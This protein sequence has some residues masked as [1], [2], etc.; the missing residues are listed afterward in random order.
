VPTTGDHVNLYI[1]TSTAS[2]AANAI[3]GCIQDPDYLTVPSGSVSITVAQNYSVNNPLMVGHFSATE[4]GAT[5]SASNTGATGGVSTCG[6]ITAD[7]NVTLSASSVTNSHIVTSDNGNVIV[8]GNGPG[9]PLTLANSGSLISDT[10]AVDLNAPGAEGTVSVTGTGT[11][12]APTVNVNIGSGTAS[13]TQGTIS[14]LIQDPLASTTQ[15][16]TVA[17]TV[18][19]AT[20]LSLGAFNSTT[21]VTATNNGDAVSGTGDVTILANTSGANG[22]TVQALGTNGNVTDVGGFTLTSPTS[23]TLLANGGPTSGAGGTSGGVGD[24]ADPILVNTPVLTANAPNGSV[25]VTDSAAVVIT[26]AN[27]ANGTNAGTSFHLEDD[28]AVAN[29]ISFA[30]GSSITAF[31]TILNTPNGGI[32]LTGANIAASGGAGTGN[33]EIVTKD[34]IAGIPTANFAPGTLILASTA[35][36]I[37]SANTPLVTGAA[38]ISASAPTGGVFVDDTNTGT[39]SVI[40]PNTAGLHCGLTITGPNT[41]ATQYFIEGS[42]SLVTGT[43][44]TV[45]APSV[46]ISAHNNIGTTGNGFS[47]AAQTLTA[48][49]GGS[50]NVA[51]N[52]ATTTTLANQTVG[53]TGTFANSAGGSFTITQTGGGDLSVADNN[54]VTGTTGV[55]IT[56]AVLNLGV[57]SDVSSSAGNVTI[58]S[59]TGL[60]LTVNMGDGSTIEAPTGAVNFDTPAFPGSIM[61][62]GTTG[63]ITGDS[64]SFNGGTGGSPVNVNVGKIDAPIS[65]TGSAVSITT[66]TGNVDVVSNIDTSSG[67]GPGG[68]VT[69]VAMGGAV[70]AQNITTNG[71]NTG[72]AGNITINSNAP[73]TFGDLSANGSAGAGAGII[74]ITA[75][76]INGGFIDDTTSGSTLPGGNVAITTTSLALSGADGAGASI[77]VSNTSNTGNG[78][79]V[80]I[81]TSTPTVFTV[82][83]GGA[84]TGNGTN[85]AIIANGVSGGFVTLTNAGN[86]TVNA[87]GLIAANG[88]TGVGGDVLIQNSTTPGTNPLIVINNGTISAISNSATTGLNG[89]N[90]GPGQT[91]TVLGNGTFIAGE[92]THIGNLN[93]TNLDFLTT[94]S[95]TIT[96]S[97]TLTFIPHF[98]TQGSV[99]IIIVPPVIKPVTPVI[100]FDN[101]GGRHHG[102]GLPGIA[103]PPEHSANAVNTTPGSTTAGNPLLGNVAFFGQRQQFPLDS[104]TPTDT[105]EVDNFANIDQMVNPVVEEKNKS[106][107]STLIEGSKTFRDEFADDEKSRLNL[108]H[109]LIGSNTQKNFFNLD[110]G[111]V[112]FNP[113]KD[114]VV[115][116]HEGEVYIAAGSSVFVMENG[117]DVV[118][119]NL[120]D[121]KHNAVTIIS[122]KKKLTLE[123]GRMLVLSRQD[124]R[125]FEKITAG[126]HGIGY[127]NIKEVDLDSSIKAFYGDF[128]IPSALTLVVPL[129][130][131]FASS[132]PA[133]RTV[134]DRILKTSVM[135]T[136][137][138]PSNSPFNG[139]LPNR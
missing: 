31:T 127:R 121:G 97:S 50:V 32:N 13:I 10:G 71:T 66:Q 2:V 137:F 34:D 99:V 42:G 6:D 65:V 20:A 73:T 82:G 77:N 124:T 118:F 44:A 85:G 36:S 12:S 87:G 37:G 52:S 1:G 119:Y 83:P 103:P 134:V 138:T 91:I 15:S 100:V 86:L 79:T 47:T 16:S 33:I 7:G 126:F 4:T 49:A 53:T 109:V 92:C 39:V 70:T 117:H 130:K 72:T 107:A 26:G 139:G 67:T 48:D 106:L 122:A 125:D 68:N 113:S 136:N 105:T 80:N 88:T 51:N 64:A 24:C 95:G 76:S 131:M 57:N 93:Q 30:G 104:K 27:S 35:G 101:N 114:I 25:R 108:E 102:S 59:S 116:T 98:C 129:K 78:G 54:N 46:V 63:T 112:V 74:T 115:Q 11:I 96:V 3:L 89:L 60:P 40:N 75:P 45:T 14:G 128:S 38:N 43:G 132:D 9:A 22:V 84:A 19:S 90:G 41:A 111:N 110:K 56:T 62:T 55:S 17:I 61:V 28:A 81:N 58:A 23:V 133:D 8:T 29:A 5:F 21:T 69:L 94:P 135:L 18:S 120:H 123:P